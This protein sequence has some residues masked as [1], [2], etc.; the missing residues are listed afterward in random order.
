MSTIMQ[1]LETIFKP[2]VLAFTVS[3]L[4]AMGLQVKM[5]EVI[6]ALKNKKAMALIFVWGW[7]LAP[8]LGY[9]ITW[10]LPLAE[11]F[12]IAV[13]LSSLAP[14]API[15]P[16][17]VAKARGDI[18]FAGAF[19]PLAMIGAVVFIPLIA[20][21]MVKGVTISPWA[22]AKPLLV[23]IFL[24]LA[25]GT[26]ARHYAETA[27]MKIFPAVNAFA[28]L[29]TLAMITVCFVLF[30]KPALGTVGSFALL[31]ATIHVVGTGL[32]TYRFGFGLKQS[33]RSVMALGNG[34]RNMAAILVAA[35][36]IPNMDPLIVTMV[37]MWGLW[38]FVLAAI[39]A[40]IFGKQAGGTVAD[41]AP[42]GEVDI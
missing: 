35:Y 13:L 6:A 11:P 24:P 37:V 26:A 38:S 31:A 27:A 17:M 9:L 15:V 21:L 18:S 41:H 29:I 12:V 40:R 30:A 4:F 1:F 33:Q 25:I 39:G 22:L 36:A 28:R 2:M 32:I 23:S 42:K 14:C 7:V 34:T 3:S 5:P 10:V 8:A 20:P 16:L 19:I